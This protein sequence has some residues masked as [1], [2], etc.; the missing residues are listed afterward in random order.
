MNSRDFL[1]LAE[2][3]ADDD[4]EAAWRTAVSRAYYAAF[5]VACDVMAALGFDVPKADRAHGYLWLRLQNCSNADVIQAGRVLKDLRTHRN[6]ADCEKQHALT[7][8]DAAKYLI[9]AKAIVATLDQT[10]EE[11][12][13]LQITEAIKNYER[14]VLKEVTWRA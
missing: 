14:D 10:L 5:H 9:D 11:E 4:S 2:R 6:R 13:S 12:I 3:L 1:P 8:Q 7:Q